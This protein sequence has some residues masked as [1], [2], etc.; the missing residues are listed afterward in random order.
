MLHRNFSAYY[1]FQLA[2]VDP[3]SGAVTVLEKYDLGPL[4]EI[5][6]VAE[7]RLVPLQLARIVRILG[8]NE[9]E[10]EDVAPENDTSGEAATE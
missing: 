3:D 1:A 10:P 6:T 9:R 5:E 2:D 8:V 4:F 7:R